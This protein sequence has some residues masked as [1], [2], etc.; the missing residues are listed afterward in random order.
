MEAG[1]SPDNVTRDDQDD[2]HCNGDSHV[3]ALEAVFDEGAVQVV[4]ILA[5]E[6]ATGTQDS[7]QPGE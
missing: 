3:D 5:N 7:S 6:D 2:E 4:R 1:E